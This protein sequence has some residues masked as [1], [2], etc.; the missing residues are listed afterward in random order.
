MAQKTKTNDDDELHS[1]RMAWTTGRSD[2]V[3]VVVVVVVVNKTGD[4]HQVTAR[5]ECFERDFGGTQNVSLCVC[6]DTKSHEVRCGASR[7]G[8]RHGRVGWR[9]GILRFA[10]AFRSNSKLEK[11]F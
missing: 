1:T 3:V 4:S 9:F 6:S 7:D 11:T 8:T 10:R 2:Y 5:V